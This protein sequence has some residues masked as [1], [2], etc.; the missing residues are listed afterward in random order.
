MG[1]NNKR[2]GDGIDKKRRTVLRRSTLVGGGFASLLS[3]PNSIASSHLVYG[4]TGDAV[5]TLSVSS[6]VGAEY[7]I[8]VQGDVAP[9]DN[10]DTHP[11]EYEDTIRCA[12][13][14]CTIHG[15]LGE[16]G[17]DSY[18]LSGE[19]VS[20][21][22]DGSVTVTVDG[23]PVQSTDRQH[24]EL[25]AS[26][27]GAEYWFTVRGDVSAGSEAD[28][29]SHD[30]QDTINCGSGS[31]EVHGYLGEGGVDDYYVEGEI[32]SVEA[33]G[34]VTVRVDGESMPVEDV[35]GGDS[36]ESSGYGD[37]S[38]EFIGC[39]EEV[40]ISNL[41][42]DFEWLAIRY[43]KVFYPDGKSMYKSWFEPSDADFQD[44]LENGEIQFSEYSA[45]P[46]GADDSGM[47]FAAVEIY[48][49]PVSED[50]RLHDTLDQE[51]A[52]IITR[53]D[54]EECINEQREYDKELHGN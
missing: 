47:V 33:E 54:L 27:D 18:Q 6:T 42:T 9:G 4:D 31:C 43:Y 17:S 50:Q 30:V 41:G 29:Y 7:W 19:V 11:H 8:T 51:P 14:S 32:V 45:I 35:S 34:P 46:D 52:R 49:T 21:R 44:V 3:W 37:V 48:D 5:S 39:R 13:G 22:A 20:V 28:T 26:S 10:A 53:D 16:G 2:H 38:V 25:L 24:V 1:I 36:N 15:Y 12:N 40:H 23:E